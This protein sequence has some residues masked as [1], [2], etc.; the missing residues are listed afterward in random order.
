MAVALCM[1][2]LFTD[3]VIV[4]FRGVRHNLQCVKTLFLV[5]G[6]QCNNVVVLLT[7]ILENVK[8]SI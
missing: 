3:R 5:G 6:V 4:Q 2:I 8:C 7:G 1:F